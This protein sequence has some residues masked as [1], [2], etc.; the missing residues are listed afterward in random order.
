MVKS[1]EM[2]SGVLYKSI[3]L[4]EY[5]NR[6]IYAIKKEIPEEHRRVPRM[7]FFITYYNEKFNSI[8]QSDIRKAKYV[9]QGNHP[10][11]WKSNFEL[12]E[13]EVL[14]AKF[15]LLNGKIDGLKSWSAFIRKK[16]DEI[17][18]NKDFDTMEKLYDFA[19]N[20]I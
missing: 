9:H 4:S 14:V 15:S 17:E 6:N 1:R 3:E 19:R 7:T 13:D 10:R 8:S 2:K 20:E 5:I 12:V 11:Q 16:I 18:D